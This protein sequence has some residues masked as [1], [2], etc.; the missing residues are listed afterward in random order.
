MSGEDAFS[1]IQFKD[2]FRTEGDAQR[3]LAERLPE[4]IPAVE[5]ATNVEIL[6]GPVFVRT[7]NGDAFESDRRLVTNTGPAFARLFTFER[8][9][10][11]PLP[12]ALARPGAAV[13]TATTA[14]RYFGDDDPIGQPLTVDGAEATV[15]AVV[16]D[17]PPNARLR[18][19][20]ALQ[21]DRIPN[22]GAYH[23]V[24]LAEGADP[25]AVAA[26]VTALLDDLFPRRT[27]D[28]GY[29]ETRATERLQ[30]LTAIHLAE[31][32]LYDDTPHRAPVYLWAFGAIGLLILVITTINYANLALALY[33][34]RHQEIGV[35]KA[36]GGHRRQI[37][38]QFLVEALLLALVCVPLA[39]FACAAVLP[40]FNALMETSIGGARLVQPVVLGAL[41]GVAA[42]A[43][44]AAGGYPAFVLARQ[45]AVDLFGAGLASSGGRGWSLR[46]G[47]IALQF[48]VLVG[49]GSLSWVAY[50]QLAFMQTSDLGYETERVV[51]TNVR[52]DSAAYQQYRQRLLSSSA[53]EAVGMGIAPNFAGNTGTFGLVGGDRTFPGRYR[54]VDMHWFDVMGLEHPVVARMQAQGPTGPPRALVN[55]AAADRLSPVDPVGRMW[56]FA[57]ENPDA[58]TY[59]IAGVMPNLHL[60]SMRRAIVPTL[61]QVFAS[62]SGAYNILVRVADGRTRAGLAHVRAVTAERFPDTPL[63]LTFLDDQV[64][65]LYEQERRFMTLASTLAGLAIVLAALGL[66]SLTA[67]LTRLRMKEIGVRKSLGASVGSIVALLNRE[68]VQIVGAAFLVGAP[69]AWW[70]A[71]AWLGQFAYRVG[72]SPLVFVAVGAGALALA[73]AAVTWQSLAAARVDPAQVLRAE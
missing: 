9:A 51:L 43:G 7:A 39:L 56:S 8:V 6:T 2:F 48:A 73:V 69:L 3:L 33:A 62:P 31:R 70:A 14:R 36:L 41:V 68:Y 35:R 18:F 50:D 63:R 52:A 5:E 23:Y 72:V 37:A 46:H 58:T 71:S 11:A 22:W 17:P 28:R 20:V 15:R 32:A 64:E 40:A 53:I 13:L 61:F 47:L 25:E 30:P 55:Q 44:L 19:D 16:A 49:L 59:T 67:Y 42:L 26:Q 21:V 10:G 1:T 57:P 54:R 34:G 45:Q 12:E 4:A 60:T 38:G 29:N 65:Q 24:R 66:A 27:E